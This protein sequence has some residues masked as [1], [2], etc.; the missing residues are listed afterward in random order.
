MMKRLFTER[1]GEGKDRVREALDPR[2]LAA[3]EAKT[4]PVADAPAV[5][6]LAEGS[7]H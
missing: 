4:L 6:R 7:C 3:P 2:Y 1:H 5:E